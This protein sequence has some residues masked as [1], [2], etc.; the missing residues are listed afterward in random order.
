MIANPLT[1]YNSLSREKEIFTSLVPNRVGMYV[2][3]PTV[4]SDVHLGNC[5]TF[6]TFDLLFRYLQYLGYK[7]RYV[8]NITDVGHL[9]NDLADEG[10]D[11]IAKKARLESLEPMEIV[12]RYTKG[13]HQVMSLLNVLD[14]SI[15]PSATGHISEQIEMIKKIISRGYGYESNGSVYFDS[16]SYFKDYPSYGQLS[17]KKVDDLFTETRTLKSQDEKRNASD[18]ALWMKADQRH[19][20]QWPSPWGQ[21]FP[22]WH[23]ECSA[24]STKYLGERFDIHGG[25]MDLQFPHHENEIAQN[26]GSCGHTPSN[27]WMHGNMMTLN[28]KK[29]SKRDGNTIL[30]SELFTGSN[31]LMS[32]SYSPMTLRF[33]CLQTHYRSTLD[34]SDNALSAAEKGYRR[35]IDAKNTIQTLSSQSTATSDLDSEIADLCHKSFEHLSDDL[36]TPMALAR[37]F[38][39]ANKVFS[40]KDGHIDIIIHEVTKLLLNETFEGVINQVL[41]LIDDNQHAGGRQ[42]T[43]DGLMHLILDIRKNAREQK[44]WTT[45][46]KIRDVLNEL[47]I[48]VKDSKDETT[49]S[50][51]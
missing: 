13:F 33:L 22:G 48:N 27:Y 46:D 21:G 9:E 10:E 26:V 24:M 43:L 11:K 5:R 18:F 47:K 1:I 19:I 39:L 32:K 15:E 31:P 36:N 41:G 38:D 45:S 17:G 44:D 37:L 8:R 50:I 20:M 29:M 2:C 40:L 4:Y 35:L 6:I 12:Q 25:G 49:W 7:V 30:P 51:N 16:A 3:G 42:D 14:P 28:G 34:L 23:L